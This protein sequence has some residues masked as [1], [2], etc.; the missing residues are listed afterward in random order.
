MINAALI[1]FG[2]IAVSHRQ[3]Y[4]NLERQGIA[5]LVAACD[6][7]PKAFDRKIKINLDTGTGIL[8]EKLNFYT[9]L[10]RMLEKEKIDLIDICLPTYLHAEYAS[11]MLLA[12]YNVMSEKPMALGAED[13]EVMLRAA[14]ESGKHLMIG[15]CLRFYPAFDFVKA[16]I[17]DGSFGEL[18]SASFSRLSAPPTWGFENWFMDPERSGGCMT[19]LHVHDVD[20]IR[21]LFGEP[22]A[23][24]CRASSSVSRH[25]TVH[26]CFFYGGKP[27]SAIGDWT[28]TGMS[29]RAEAI[30]GF[31]RATL[32]IDGTKLTVYPKDGSESYL[33]ELCNIS[34]I[35]GELAYF[36]GVITGERENTK[37]PPESAARTIRLVEA[38][39]ESADSGGKLIRFEP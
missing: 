8:D 6:V 18:Q 7:D 3:A 32:K 39:R 38:L 35:E 31:E 15:Q 23:V 28:L 20:I 21:Y 2:G 37:N 19:D 25:D 24:E 14:R 17:E 26:S 36:S 29:F 10:D 11:R 9:D 4:A 33:A 16:A 1:G 5:K 13:C 34:G 27:V 22:E 12:G 30:I